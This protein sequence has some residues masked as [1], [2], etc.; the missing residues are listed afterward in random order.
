MPDSRAYYQVV[1]TPHWILWDGACDFCAW[2]IAQVRRRDQRGR[3]RIVPYQS[4]P[5]AL[6]ARTTPDAL[7]RAI[8]VFTADGRMLRGGRAVL[9]IA[10]QL[11]Y[12]W[13]ARPLSFPPFIWGVEAVYWIIARLRGTLSRWMRLGDA[14][15]PR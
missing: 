7:R 9:F 4:A 3:F 12:G 11:G 5:P 14:E 1:D 6:L 10:E 15:C 8:H 2:S 13:L